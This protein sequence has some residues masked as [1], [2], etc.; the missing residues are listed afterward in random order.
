MKVDRERGVSLIPSNS[1]HRARVWT[2]DTVEARHGSRNSHCWPCLDGRVYKSRGRRDPA[3][4]TLFARVSRVNARL[5]RK[6][7]RKERGGL[8]QIRVTRV[9][10]G[11]WK[12]LEGSRGLA[13]MENICGGGVSWWKVPF[14][15]M[16]P[17]ALSDAIF[18]EMDGWY[19]AK[20][21]LSPP[22]II[23]FHAR[24]SFFFFFFF[25]FVVTPWID[26]S[27]F[28]PSRV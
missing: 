10:K 17:R 16:I 1:Y 23:L 19:R 3:T 28:P 4:T 5:G 12:T 21:S 11:W 9:M 7:G 18:G 20:E 6:K 24:Q 13:L 8:K 27:H 26:H 15:L 22:I 25:C 2:L 14:R